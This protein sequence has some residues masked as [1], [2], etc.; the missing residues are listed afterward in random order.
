MCDLHKEALRSRRNVEH[1]KGYSTREKFV[2]IQIEK[3]KILKKTYI[4][5][6][7]KK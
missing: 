2:F 7:L 1:S 4:N 6:T 3:L 5:Q